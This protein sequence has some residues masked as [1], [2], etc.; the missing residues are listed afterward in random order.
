MSVGE[1]PATSSRDTGP[2]GSVAV[3]MWW[4]PSRN[5]S[6]LS[7]IRRGDSRAY[8]TGT[9]RS[10]RGRRTLLSTG[11]AVAARSGGA[12]VRTFDFNGSRRP[13]GNLRRVEGSGH[14]R[15]R[16][17][18]RSSTQLSC[19]GSRNAGSN[20]LPSVRTRLHGRAGEVERLAEVLADGPVVTLIGPGGVGKTRLALALAHRVL[21]LARRTSADGPVPA[22]RLGQRDDRSWTSTS[23]K[24][25][26]TA[27]GVA[28][29]TSSS[30][31]DSVASTCGR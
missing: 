9:C 7:G 22:T 21:D 28:S 26:S 18:L 10:L 15:R 17:R 4:R 27:S 23:E 30:G 3:R 8:E 11:E 19:P 6:R 29:A 24:A 25:T 12:V 13:G 5:S 14:P 2:A 16:A 31:W 1:E 20:N